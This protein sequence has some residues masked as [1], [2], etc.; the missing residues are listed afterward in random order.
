MF[1]HLA[2]RVCDGYLVGPYPISSKKLHPYRLTWPGPVIGIPI[3]RPAIHHLS[4]VYE[5]W[6]VEAILLLLSIYCAI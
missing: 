4:D 5:N 6:Q 3:E 2:S 1:V